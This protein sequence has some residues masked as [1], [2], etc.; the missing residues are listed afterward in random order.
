MLE[1]FDMTFSSEPTSQKIPE[2]KTYEEFAQNL[3]PI[4][5]LREFKAEDT[6]LEAYIDRIEAVSPGGKADIFDP[7]F[8]VAYSGF[9]KQVWNDEFLPFVGKGAEAQ[10]KKIKESTNYIFSGHAI[11]FSSG[12][13]IARLKY[14]TFLHTPEDAGISPEVQV[15]V[16]QCLPKFFRDQ[17]NYRWN[18]FTPDILVDLERERLE[19]V[20][21]LEEHPDYEK[22]RAA[23]ESFRVLHVFFK[24]IRYNADEWFSDITQKY[25]EKHGFNNPE[26]NAD[27]QG[28]KDELEKVVATQFENIKDDV[29]SNIFRKKMDKGTINKAKREP[30]ELLRKIIIAAPLGESLPTDRIV[31]D[32][33]HYSDV[34][35]DIFRSG[36]G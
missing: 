6:K 14:R 22:F 34:S 32:A 9:T 3:R 19:Y 10:D 7:D 17:D 23:T 13:Q 15:L 21:Q 25:L 18:N 11:V 30:D 29:F 31:G 12:E 24:N 35:I 2:P 8:W 26:F 16:K 36:N 28:Y 27:I 5:N 33:N 4:R 20:R 1:Y